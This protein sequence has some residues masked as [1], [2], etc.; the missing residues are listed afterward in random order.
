MHNCP[1]TSLGM[2]L[3]QMG[4]GMAGMRFRVETVWVW[5]N[6]SGMRD[7]DSTSSMLPVMKIQNFG[8]PVQATCTTEHLRCDLVGLTFLTWLAMVSRNRDDQCNYVALYWRMGLTHNWSHWAAWWRIKLPKIVVSKAAGKGEFFT[9][10]WFEI[11]CICFKILHNWFPVVAFFI[12]KFDA[13]LECMCKCAW[14][15]HLIGTWLVLATAMW[16]RIV[17]NRKVLVSW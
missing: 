16:T 8:C 17:H 4:T 6:S 1:C 15:L 7:W 13:L 3:C 5:Q 9:Y 11:T 12:A 10:F 2:G 14:I